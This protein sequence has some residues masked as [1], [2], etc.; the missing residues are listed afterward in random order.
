LKL[1]E[2]TVLAP[3]K[4]QEYLLKKMPDN[5]KSIFL[6]IAGYTLKNW[7]RLVDDIRKQL[8][9]LDAL[10]V[11]ESPFGN[12]YKILGVLSGP[13]GKKLKIVSIWMIESESKVAKF[14]TL[15]PDKE[16]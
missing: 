13:N 7:K 10:F 12:L 9:P 14:I 6:G 8:L 11:R 4:F 3:E 1:P 16:Q 5:D 15:Y 2:N